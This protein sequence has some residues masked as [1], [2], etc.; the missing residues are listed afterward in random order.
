MFFLNMDSLDC[1]HFKGVNWTL[2][3]CLY[4][5]DVIK[6]LLLVLDPFLI[7]FWAYILGLYTYYFKPH[8]MYVI[9]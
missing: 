4:L 3:F 2:I 1:Q 7:S 8:H 5:G 6:D 9:I